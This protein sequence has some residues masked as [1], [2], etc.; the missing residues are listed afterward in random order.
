MRKT[1]W[2]RECLLQEGRYCKGLKYFQVIKFLTGVRYITL[3]NLLS[4][5]NFCYVWIITL[6]I[7]LCLLHSQ[8]WAPLEIMIMRLSYVRMTLLSIDS[9]QAD[10]FVTQAPVKSPLPLSH[11]PVKKG[12]KDKHFNSHYVHLCSSISLGE[13]SSLVNLLQ[14]KLGFWPCPSLVKSC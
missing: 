6:L 5:V 10:L 11:T 1:I 3:S 12:C 4:S 13:C 14:S 2:V 9:H 8:T 7:L